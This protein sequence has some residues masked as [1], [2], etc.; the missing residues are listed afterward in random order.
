MTTQSNTTPNKNTLVQFLI[1]CIVSAVFFTL[2]FLTISTTVQSVRER[3]P[4]FAVLKSVGYSDRAVLAL[5]MG[6][7]FLLCLIPAL[8][9][10][11]A[12]LGLS[13]HEFRR[14]GG[15][16]QAASSNGWQRGAGVR[17][18]LSEYL[19]GRCRAPLSVLSLSKRGR[20]PTHP[21]PPRQS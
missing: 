2:L 9:G 19:F 15:E 6:E 7:S 14:K 10:L 5:V 4:E 18:G 17:I 3:I 11:A 1:T 20:P 16:G 8:L 13:G 21:T 12:T